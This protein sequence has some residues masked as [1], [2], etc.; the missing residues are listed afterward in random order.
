MTNSH[1][2]NVIILFGAIYIMSAIIHLSCSNNYKNDA[3]LV[4]H[5]SAQTG[6]IATQCK[7]CE[8]V[9]V[10]NQPSCE[11]KANT[12][13]IDGHSLPPDHF[14]G[15]TIEE[16]M[17]CYY[18]LDSSIELLVLNTCYGAE[19]QT[20]MDLSNNREPLVT[21]AIPH[22]IPKEGIAKL[23]GIFDAFNGTNYGELAGSICAHNPDINF[24][25]LRRGAREFLEKEIAA[26]QS[27]V[28]NC[29]QDAYDI[30]RA[31]PDMVKKRYRFEDTGNL[32]DG[33]VL[34]VIPSGQWCPWCP[35]YNEL[36]TS[37]V[38]QEARKE[39]EAY[40]CPVL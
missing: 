28:L 38:R 3:I 19:A 11:G 37:L 36:K 10:L 9:D 29:R 18:K 6:I 30:V 15:R 8:V 13:L 24:T 2:N 21:I 27:D 33:E 25:F 7:R 4:V 34:F 35:A 26:V 5:N 39:S 16:F 32:I 17:Q 12:I 14:I 1:L 23:G 31:D 20:Y 40:Q 22:A